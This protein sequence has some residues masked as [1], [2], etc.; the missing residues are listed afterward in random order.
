MERGAGTAVADDDV[1]AGARDGV[2]HTHARMHKHTHTQNK[3]RVY[4][5][6]ARMDTSL[7]GAQSCPTVAN[8]RIQIPSHLNTGGGDVMASV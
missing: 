6:V 7:L 1:A 3:G 5:Y 2:E 4:I 8:T